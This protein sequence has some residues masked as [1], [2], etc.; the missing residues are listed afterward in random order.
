MEFRIILF[1]LVIITVVFYLMIIAILS[2][3]RHAETHKPAKFEDLKV[4]LEKYL[5]NVSSDQFPQPK[6][7]DKPEAEQGY[8]VLNGIK[9]KLE[10]CKDL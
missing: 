7:L 10:D 1:T 5:G 8:V 2:R 3:M 4:K 9:R 6:I